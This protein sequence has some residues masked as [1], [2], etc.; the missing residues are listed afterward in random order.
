MI[1]RCLSTGMFDSNTYILGDNGEGAVIDAGASADEICSAIGELNLTIKYIILTHGHIDHI[2]STDE[3]RDATGAEVLIHEDDAIFLSKPEYNLS[4]LVGRVKP[5]KS[6]DVLLKDTD[7]L[8]LGN[9]DLKIIHTPGHTP[10]S[11]CVKS[12]NIIFTGDTLF[13]M[14]IGRVDLP[15][16]S[17]TGIMDSLNGRLM[18]L[19]DDTA[20]YPG[21]GEDTTIGF[22]RKF[23]PYVRQGP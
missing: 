21:H 7:I 10:G 6:A 5:F 23:N 22:E 2:C 12:G 18:R 3:L 4:S 9:L 20:V 16:G 19:D 17:Y 15:K 8:K 14:S 1:L 11:I 13:K